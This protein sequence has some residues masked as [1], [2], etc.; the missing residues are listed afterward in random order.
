MRK[1]LVAHAFGAGA[2]D[3]APRAE[4]R[5]VSAEWEAAHRKVQ[6]EA[7]AARSEAAKARS[8]KP[9]GT[10]ASE[11][12]NSV[13]TGSRPSTNAGARAIA[14]LSGTNRGAVQRGAP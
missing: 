1:H 11:H 13:R 4:G 12:T 5:A 9:D 3:R 7:N 10:L 6:A 8:R 2:A 14:E